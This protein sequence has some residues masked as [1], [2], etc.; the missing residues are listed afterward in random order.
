MAIAETYPADAR[1]QTL[2]ANARSGHVQPIVQ[3]RVARQQGLH[4]RVGTPDVLGVARECRPP[5]RSD[6]TAKEWAN[7]G[8]DKAREVEGINDP[9][10]LCHLADV[11]A[12]VKRRYSTPVKLEHRAH[13]LGHGLLGGSLYTSGVGGSALFPL[14]KRPAFGQIAVDRIV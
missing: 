3:M 13:V 6:A 9:F 10:V 14:R 12:V 5:E 11:I 2:K 7:V 4:L 1:R 8:R